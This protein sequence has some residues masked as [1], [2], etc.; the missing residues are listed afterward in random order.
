[1]KN[2]KYTLQKVGVGSG[3]MAQCTKCLLYKRKQLS[4]APQHLRKSWA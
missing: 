4:L 2:R 1:M 3:E